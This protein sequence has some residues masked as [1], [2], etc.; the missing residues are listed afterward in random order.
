ML[1]I[2][3][4]MKGIGRI[5]RSAGTT[6]P[7][8]RDDIKAMLRGFHR[9]GRWNLLE[10]VRDGQVS[11][12]QLYSMHTAGTL[13]Q[14][15]TATVLLPFPDTAIKWVNAYTDI[16]PPSRHNYTVM[17]NVVAKYGTVSAVV[18]DLP[19][20]LETMRKDYLKL[21]KPAYFNATRNAIR[22]FVKNTEGQYSDLYLKVCQVKPLKPALD[23]KGKAHPIHK[24]WALKSVLKSTVFE[25]LWAMCMTGTGMNELQNGLT[26]QGDRILVHGTKMDAKDGRRRRYVPV[27]GEDI[28]RTPLM[29]SCMIRRHLKAAEL[30][31]QIYD[32]RRSFALM[33][34]EAG[35]PYNRVQLYM[36]HLPRNVTEAYL[37]AD[38][39]TFIKEDGERLQR[40]IAKHKTLKQNKTIGKFFDV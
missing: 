35:I 22:S 2:D 6:D 23:K 28:T 17:Y 33:C 1:T 27:T 8:V 16:K 11:A 31:I 34:Q 19:K 36:G 12:M 15:P 25:T 18:G 5:K 14:T 32:M 9:T 40:Y 21:N 29:R 37:K 10:Q 26:Q 38:V 20:M 24:I 13:K 7:T 39:D 4:Q 3:L 30:D